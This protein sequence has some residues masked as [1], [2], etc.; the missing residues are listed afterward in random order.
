M[1][2]KNKSVISGGTPKELAKEL[3]RYNDHLA[4]AYVPI[5]DYTT[6][7][8]KDNKEYQEFI[9]ALDD[10]KEI[11]IA[12][13]SIITIP[14]ASNFLVALKDALTYLFS[15]CLLYTSPSPRDLSTSRM[16]SSA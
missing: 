6:E 16:P 9:K 14:F 1:A 12:E 13:G 8:L 15:T 3:K 7:S 5:T 2:K 10:G 11:T 4:T